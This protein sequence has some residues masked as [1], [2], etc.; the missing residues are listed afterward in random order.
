MAERTGIEWADATWNPWW[1]CHKVSTGCKNC[2]MFRDMKRFGKDPDV[3]RKTSTANFR[4]PLKWAKTGAVRERGRI[5]TCSYSDWF[6]EEADDFRPEAW[7]IIKMTPQ[8]DYLIL[9]KRPERIKDHL[10]PDWG[11]GYPN[12]WLGVS[13]ENQ[14]T[15]S[16]RFPLLLQVPAAIRWVSAEPLLGPLTIP[17]WSIDW[18]VGGGE[19]DKLNPRPSEMEWFRHLAEQC[20]LLNIP[21][22]HKQHGGSKKIDGAWG[23]RELDGKKWDRFPK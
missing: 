7:L 15:F 8:F 17:I 19:S 18:I 16:A 23:G 5:F 10:P 20:R 3:V 11:E 22:F 6:I 13:A 1:G 9:T 14:T 2:Y 21:Y 12:V 4:S